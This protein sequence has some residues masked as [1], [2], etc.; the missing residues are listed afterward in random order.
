[1]PCINCKEKKKT[2]KICKHSFHGKVYVSYKVNKFAN[3]SKNY[4]YIS[5]NI[6][7]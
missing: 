3:Y 6:E 2:K 1:M 4:L 7:K 5:E